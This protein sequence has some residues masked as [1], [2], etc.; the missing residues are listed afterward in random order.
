MYKQKAK[1]DGVLPHCLASMNPKSKKTISL[2]LKLKSGNG[3]LYRPCSHFSI[4]NGTE[5]QVNW[6]TTILIANVSSK[7]WWE[8]ARFN[9]ALTPAH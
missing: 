8:W 9:T 4:F 7:N 1:R 6:S 2:V 5:G 3:V